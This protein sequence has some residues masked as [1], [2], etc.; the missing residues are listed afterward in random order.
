M[1]TEGWVAPGG[2][3]NIGMYTGWLMMVGCPAGLASLK[4]A[5]MAVCG[6]E[7]LTSLHWCLRVLGCL[8]C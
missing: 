5:A 2:V 3:I 1:K 6:F 4:V 7:L 8:C